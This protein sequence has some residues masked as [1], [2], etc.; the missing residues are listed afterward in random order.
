LFAKAQEYVGK[1]FSQSVQDP[2]K[3]T[4]E[5]FGQRYI[6]VRAASMS[7]DFFEAVTN[8]YEDSGP[9]NAGNVARSLLFDIAHAIGKMD[10]R[11]FHKQMGLVD[12]IE[13][14]STGPVHFSHTG[15]AFVDIFPE[16]RPTPDEDY[17]L[18]YDHPFSFESDAWI[19]A[20]KK[21]DFPVCV[22]NA[23]YSSGWCEE[24]FGVTLVA[25]EIMCKAEGD[26]VCRFIMAHPSR[27]DGYIQ[28]Y[29][30]EN[31]QFMKGRP[32]YKI[33]GF[34]ERKVV[35]EKLRESEEKYRRLFEEALDAIFVADA[36]TGTLV[37]CND[38]AAKLVGRE[39]SE[40]IGRHQSILHPP[41]EIEGQFSET[42]RRLLNAEG[43]QLLETRVITKDGRTK[44]VAIKAN[45]LEIGGK[46]VLQ[47]IFRDVTKQKKAE[48]EI[49]RQQE[50]LE[51]IFEVTP[52]GMLLVDGD[53]VAKKVNNVVAK[54]VGRESSEILNK[55]PGNGLG[56]IRSN[57]HPMGCGHGAVCQRCPLRKLVTSVLAT[58]QAIRKEEVQASFTVREKDVNLW[59]EVSAEPVKIDGSRHVVVA[60]N[61]IT[62]RKQAD[63][64]LQCAKERAE[65][66]EDELREA[67]AELKRFN[68]LTL[69]RE[70]RIIEMKKEVN[71]CCADLGREPAYESVFDDAA[72]EAPIVPSNREVQPVRGD[73]ETPESERGDRE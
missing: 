23:G 66:S 64:Q 25:Q 53:M 13:K 32:E 62:E 24:S 7:I 49:K 68:D 50:N 26:E 27:I 3:G 71:T 46:R 67:M 19:K 41:K 1:Y 42:F 10:A 20:G 58:G 30:N 61:N 38:T 31:P 43:E 11:N 73:A 37:D 57:D 8:L 4:I 55:E 17:Y 63:D 44:D 21:A 33:P 5:I 56:C 12:P 45:M 40:I 16:S 59:L 35:E 36:E 18:V 39:K 51:A 72:E 28:D 22:M 2:T 47:G 52:V 9:E 48:E 69:G 15:W 70:L 54:L 14:L 34:F 6:L 29:L 60:I 65:K